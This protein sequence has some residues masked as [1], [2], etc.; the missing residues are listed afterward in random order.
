MLAN[1]RWGLRM[2]RTICW[3]ETCVPPKWLA[4]TKVGSIPDA[5]ASCTTKTDD[6]PPF[7][8][9]L[10]GNQLSGAIPH[11]YSYLPCGSFLPVR[12][13]RNKLSGTIPSAF[14]CLVLSNLD[15]QENELSGAV[16]DLSFWGSALLNGNKL[17]GAL[18][19]L[20]DN[21]ITSPLSLKGCFIR[22]CS[23]STEYEQ[24]GQKHLINPKRLFLRKKVNSLGRL[25]CP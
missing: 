15:L 4:L 18:P 7:S 9:D 6:R 24:S 19:S 14:A 20:D 13:G 3:L 25:L 2:L 17:T 5:I 23:S 12:L 10:V 22:A 21:H 16:P 11:A 8:V 1:F